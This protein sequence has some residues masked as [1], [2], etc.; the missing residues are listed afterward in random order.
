MTFS[1]TKEQLAKFDAWSAKHKR[2]YTGASGGRY[3]WSFTPTSLGVAL[4]V[5]DEVTKQEI[6]LTDYESW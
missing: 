3:T 6:D 2:V 4:V 1:A 5:T